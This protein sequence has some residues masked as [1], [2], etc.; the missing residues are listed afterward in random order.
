MMGY[1]NNMMAGWG[2]FGTITWLFL[3]V[4]LGLGIAW[5][6]KGINKK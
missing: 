4:F 6:W 5:F 2:L 1:Y 3:I